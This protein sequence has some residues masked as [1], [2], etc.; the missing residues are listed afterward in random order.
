MKRVCLLFAFFIITI[1][2]IAQSPQKMSYQMV[3]RN[4]SNVLIAN[5]VVGVKISLL[6]GSAT[7][8]AVFVETHAP[9]TNANGLASLVIG[10]GTAVT[11]IFAN[12]DW[13]NGPYFIK[14]E[15]D[16]TGGTNYTITGTSQLM[17]VPYALY[18]GS[19][20]NLG[21]THLIISGELT[22][23]EAAAKIA[24][25]GG[26]NTQFVWIQYTSN[27]TTV[28][29]SGLT[30][31]AEVVIQKNQKL[32]TFIAPNLISI[33]SKLSIVSNEALTTISFP[34]LNKASLTEVQNNTVLSSLSF[35]ALGKVASDFNIANNKILS[36]IS[37]PVLINTGN[38]LIKSNEIL[39]SINFPSLKTTRIFNVT[40]NNSLSS[41][42]LPLLDTASY[43]EVV[44][45]SLANLSVPTLKTISGVGDYPNSNHYGLHIQCSNGLASISFPNLKNVYEVVYIEV[46]GA[47]SLSFATLLSAWEIRLPNTVSALTSISLRQ[48]VS[49]HIT[50]PQ[51]AVLTTISAPQLTTGDVSIANVPLL[52]SLSFPQLVSSNF[53]LSI[54]NSLTTVLLPQKTTGNTTVITCPALTSIYLPLLTTSLVDIE[55]TNALASVSLPALTTGGIVLKNGDFTS[56]SAPQFVTASTGIYISATKTTGI[57]FPQLTTASDITI[58]T[59][60]LTTSISFSALTSVNGKLSIT[61]LTGLVSLATPQ[62]TTCNIEVNSCNALTAISFPQLTIAGINIQNVSSLASFSA[63]Q[64]ITSIAN[65]DIIISNVIAPVSLTQLSTVSGALNIGSTS[66]ISLPLLTSVNKDVLLSATSFDIPQLITIGGILSIQSSLIVSISLPALTTV[67]SDVEIKGANLIS[68]SLPSIA[69]LGTTNSTFRIYQSKLPVSNINTLLNKLAN[70][71]PVIANKLINLKQLTA[72]PPTGQGIIDRATL[73]A[74]PNTVLTD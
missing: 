58:S 11:G 39:P 7:G 62:L 17:S 34:V 64:L 67:G 38:V 15:T 74:R 60:T 3:V 37:A 28:N 57:S 22:D 30:N 61:S 26:P 59:N 6:Q 52:S 18:A 36:S 69:A 63:P 4:S 16:P 53:Y 46:P 33:N 31:L 32:T 55:G 2:V 23:T 70:I 65:K 27:L 72:T 56:F 35:P 12:V 49:S 48:L 9:T 20:Q 5:Q 13:A 41:L 21:K 45:N 24:A 51:A 10:D 25:E 42:S 66:T 71:T 73:A 47:T 1:N 19:T 43:F 68:C 44:S 50:I 54:C 8:T 14:T 40:D 29:I